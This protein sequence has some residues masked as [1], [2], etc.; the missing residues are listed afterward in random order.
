MIGWLKSSARRMVPR[1][2]CITKLRPS[3]GDTV[4]LTFDDGPHPRTTPAVLDLLGRYEAKAIFFVVG[5]RIHRAP[6]MLRRILDEGHWLGNH[7]Y[8]H[9]NDRRVSCRDYLTDLQRCQEA[10]LEH[11]GAIPQF[12]RPPCGNIS[13]ASLFAPRRCDLVTVNWSC[14]SQD[15]RLRSNAA[16]ISRAEEMAEEI[17]RRDVVLFHDERLTTVAA[18]NHLLPVLKSRGLQLSPDLG[19][20]L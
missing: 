18:L 13:L 8:S 10:I 11:T 17:D 2:L 7:T 4:L 6:E 16:A 12:H 15:W 9:P 1:R 20:V 3:A 5:N 19:Q 14:S